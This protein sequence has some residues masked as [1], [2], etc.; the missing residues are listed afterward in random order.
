MATRH[1]SAA[2]VRSERGLISLKKAAALVDVDRK[3]IRHWIDAGLLQ[4]YKLNGNM[5]RVNLHEVLALARPV[6][7]TDTDGAA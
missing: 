1:S 6:I 2:E 3:T 5:W 7:T 4:G